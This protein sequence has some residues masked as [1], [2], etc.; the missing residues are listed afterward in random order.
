MRH[1]CSVEKLLLLHHQ[2]VLLLLLLLKQEFLS[3]EEPLWVAFYLVRRDLL[4]NARLICPVFPLVE[5]FLVLLLIQ[6]VHLSH[7]F[8]FVQ[9]NNKASLV[10]MVFLNAF[11]AED[12]QMVGAV[13]VL[14]SLVVLVAKQ[15]VDALFIL[16]IDISQNVVSLHY[17]VQDI[18]VEGEFV[19]ALYLL[20]KL[21][22][23]WASHSK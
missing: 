9:V 8:N 6:S 17:F 4:R 10:G 20:N 18:E 12:C 19:H 2:I 21:S 23:N 1:V 3:L 13:E 11:S 15:T 5:L 7:F 16:K 22:A 14:H